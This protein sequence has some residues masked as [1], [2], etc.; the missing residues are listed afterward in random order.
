MT[1]GTML[2]KGGHLFETG[3]PLEV[4]DVLVEQG[5]IVRVGADL[6]A[7]AAQVVDAR[8]RIVMPGLVNAHT[9]SNQALEKGLCDRYPLDAWM[10]IASYGGANAELTPRELYVSAMAGAIE[11]VRSGSTAVLDMPRVP[12]ADFEASA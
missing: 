7:P 6:Q 12:L 1:A 9:H 8:G 11:M 4:A 10:L 5:R 2:I 3:R